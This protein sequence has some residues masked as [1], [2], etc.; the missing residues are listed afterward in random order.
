V[1]LDNEYQAER[2]GRDA[3]AEAHAAKLR[4]EFEIA[5]R[6]MDLHRAG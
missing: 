2:W 5:A 4:G 3:E 6:F 1:R